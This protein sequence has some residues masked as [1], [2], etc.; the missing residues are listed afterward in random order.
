MVNKPI[1]ITILQSNQYQA[2]AVAMIKISS[3]TGFVIFI[4]IVLTL[5]IVGVYG[6]FWLLSL[7]YLYH[8][9]YH[10]K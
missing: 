9:G 6:Y 1:I 5:L 8:F 4:F 10:Q 3:L 7:K 2:N